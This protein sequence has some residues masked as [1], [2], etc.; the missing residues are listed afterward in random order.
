MMQLSRRSALSGLILAMS[1]AITPTAR[2]QQVAVA[3]VDG[4]VS[5]PSGQ[6]IVN[7]QV[8]MIEVDRGQVHTTA[9]DATGRDLLQNLPEGIYTLEHN[10]PAVTTYV[11]ARRQ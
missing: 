4:H 3:E 8:R 5:D 11:R 2:A 6:T 1:F 10:T 9:T 7:A